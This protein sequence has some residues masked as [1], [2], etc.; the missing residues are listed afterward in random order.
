MST[1]TPSGF[2]VSSPVNSSAPAVLRDELSFAAPM[3]TCIVKGANSASA[4]IRCLTHLD[5]VSLLGVQ[6]DSAR[7]PDRIRW[8]VRDPGRRPAGFPGPEGQQVKA[9][10]KRNDDRPSSLCH[11]EGPAAVLPGSGT[12]ERL[13]VVD[14]VV[15]TA[16]ARP[17]TE[18]LVQETMLRAWTYR[19]NLDIQHRSPRPWLITVARHLA[20]DARR[21]RRA[22]PPEA[23]LNDAPRARRRPAGR[24][25]HRRSGRP[26]RRRSS[27]RRPAPGADRNLLPRPVGGRNGARHADP[28]RHGQITHFLR[29]ARA[30][31]HP[32]SS[33]CSGLPPAAGCAG[34]RAQ[35]T[36]T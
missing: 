33:R 20:V 16:S 22:R 21:A 34:S 12:G 1:P 17:I 2:Q 8:F 24:R 15:S 28:A 36:A 9:C 32:G 13:G 3:T 6:P 29:A 30:A 25:Q 19:A 18:D 4:G 26:R 35:P 31:P 10:A 23:E 27:A 11:S 14:H 5:D 7:A